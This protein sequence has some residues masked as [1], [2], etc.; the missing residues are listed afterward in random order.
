VPI[1]QERYNFENGKAFADAMRTGGTPVIAGAGANYDALAGSGAPLAVAWDAM[2]FGT[3][4]EEALT[5][6]NPKL[7]EILDEYWADKS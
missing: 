1:A 2:I 7:Q 4:A 3:S 6:A 5:E